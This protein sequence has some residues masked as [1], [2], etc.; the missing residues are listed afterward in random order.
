MPN[1]TNFGLPYVTP[2]DAA[3]NGTWGAVYNALHTAWDSICGNCQQFAFVEYPEDKDYPLLLNTRFPGTITKVTTKT[4]D[5]TATVTVKIGS[6][7]LGG[8]ANSASTSEQEQTHSSDNSF[9]AGDDV[10]FTVSSASSDLTDLQVMVY[11]T[12]TGAGS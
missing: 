3:F 6:T 9:S 5:G 8:T 1:T 4:S 11:Y 7:A 10:K 12:R 2:L